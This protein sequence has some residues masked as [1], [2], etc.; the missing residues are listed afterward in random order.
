MEKQDAHKYLDRAMIEIG[1]ASSL[2]DYH[3]NR[4]ANSDY[5]SDI[6]SGELEKLDRAIARLEMGLHRYKQGLALER[7]SEKSATLQ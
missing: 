6:E 2:L 1:S 5:S 7:L 4:L 3:H